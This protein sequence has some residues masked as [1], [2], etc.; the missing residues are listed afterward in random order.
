MS[1]QEN[2]ETCLNA[3]SL[4]AQDSAGWVCREP[5]R[6]EWLEQQLAGIMLEL[7]LLL[8]DMES[9]LSIQNLGFFGEDDFMEMIEDMTISI[10]SLK[11][12]IRSLKE[13][14]R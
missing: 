7:Q 3:A 11:G 13:V 2:L 14:G 10:Q 9:G 12:Q 5:A 8:L 6:L 1:L 4:V